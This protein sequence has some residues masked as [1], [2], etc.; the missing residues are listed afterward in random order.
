MENADLHVP[1]SQPGI[2]RVSHIPDPHR[3]SSLKGTVT[4]VNY[5][6]GFFYI[7]LTI[8]Y[9]GWESD[10]SLGLCCLQECSWMCFWLIVTPGVMAATVS[11]CFGGGQVGGRFSLLSSSSPP[12]TATALWA[13]V[14]ASH[15]LMTCYPLISCPSSCCDK[16]H[17]Q[18]QIGKERVCLA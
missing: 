2:M 14:L 11:D 13:F 7:Y 6:L 15:T 1:S 12:H 5:V 10:S 18:K 16:H 9:E 3:L 8:V 17:H 4:A